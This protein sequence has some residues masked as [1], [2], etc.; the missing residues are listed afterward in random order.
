MHTD[1][2]GESTEEG[3]PEVAEC[4]GEVLVEEVLEELAH[5][6]IGPAAM[7]QQQTLQVAELG[8]GIV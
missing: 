7:H 6:Q 8:D 3:K 2:G 1:L 4:E 5:A